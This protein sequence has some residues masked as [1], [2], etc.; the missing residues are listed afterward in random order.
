MCDSCVEFFFGGFFFLFRMFHLLGGANTYRD[1]LFQLFVADFLFAARC[2]PMALSSSRY[3]RCSIT[4]ATISVA[5]V[6]IKG[7]F[8]KCKV[9][10]RKEILKGRPQAGDQFALG[11]HWLCSRRRVRVLVDVFHYY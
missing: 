8:I 9:V 7:R 6:M 10:D 3:P 1:R 11:L 5:N 2:A 4:V